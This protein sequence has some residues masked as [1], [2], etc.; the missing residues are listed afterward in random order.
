MR[1]RG[2]IE[3]SR[4]PSLTQSQLPGGNAT[5][6]LARPGRNTGGEEG[7]YSASKMSGARTAKKLIDA[8][9]ML[10]YILFLLLFLLKPFS[11]SVTLVCALLFIGPGT[12][13]ALKPCLTRLCSTCRHIALQGVMAKAH[14]KPTQELHSNCNCA[15]ETGTAELP[16]SSGVEQ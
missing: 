14:R 11:L 12:W 16:G 5:L 13:Q 9:Q 15:S 3:L 8:P 4:L 2:F 7:F 10:S 6:S 1:L